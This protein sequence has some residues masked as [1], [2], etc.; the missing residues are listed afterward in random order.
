MSGI[1]QAVRA[2]LARLGYRIEGTRH[3]PR[4]MFDPQALRHLEFDDVICR[5]M[6]EHGEQCRFLQ[7]GAY[8]GI[9]TDPL[10]KFIERFAWRGVMLEPQPGPAEQLRRL[11][12]EGS[13]IVVLQAALDRER[14][15]R[16]L[17]T[18]ESDTAPVWA[19]GMASF[20]RDQILKH[21]HLIPGWPAWCARSRFPA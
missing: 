11:Y 21:A 7:I 2:A 20:D 8:D 9:S 6:V 1:K 16:T 13:G 10:R 3:T 12:P 5:H 17:H 14:H 4:H 15:A 19:G 18:V